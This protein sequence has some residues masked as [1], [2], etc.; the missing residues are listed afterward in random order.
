VPREE[1]QRP[2]ERKEEEGR[3]TPVGVLG[4]DGDL[5]ADEQYGHEGDVPVSFERS[6]RPT[7][8]R[9]HGNGNTTA[10]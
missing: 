2:A 5:G 1:R 6:H 9:E 4:H 10:A 3:A 8:S 7:V